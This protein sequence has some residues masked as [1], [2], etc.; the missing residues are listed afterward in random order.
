MADQDLDRVVEA[1]G[2]RHFGKYRGEVTDNQDPLGQGR[3]Q[4]RVPAI[5]G[6]RLLWAM[7]C[8]PYAGPD[9]GFLAL[10]PVG[11]KVWIEFEQGDRAHPV[12]AGCYWDPDQLPSEAEPTTVL[13][14]TPGATV[15][16]KDDGTIEIETSGGSKLTIDGEK[17]LLEAPSIQS[18]ANGGK[19]EVSA[20][21]FDAQDGAFKVS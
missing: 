13:L 16:I 20:S 3:I 15:L 17:I 12:W 1:L 10:P 19:T 14:K 4:V 7:P 2:S 8:V 5:L 11:G 21:G 18:S 6:E 9:V